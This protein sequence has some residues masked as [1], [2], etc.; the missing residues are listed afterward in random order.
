[1]VV[2]DDQK[3]AIASCGREWFGFRARRHHGH[4]AIAVMGAPACKRAPAKG[5]AVVRRRFYTPNLCIAVSAGNLTS[6]N[7]GICL[8][9]NKL[10]AYCTQAGTEGAPATSRSARLQRAWTTA[11]RSG[12]TRF[13]NVRVAPDRSSNVLAMKTPRPR[14]P[15]ASPPTLNRRRRELVT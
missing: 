7:F 3:R 15:P 5:L 13:S 14:P 6:V 8:N 11:P 1:L 12:K 9:S 10:Q 2:L 4:V